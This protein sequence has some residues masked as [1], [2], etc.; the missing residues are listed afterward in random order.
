MLL[1]QWKCFD[2]IS[3]FNGTCFFMPSKKILNVVKAFQDNKASMQYMHLDCARGHIGKYWTNGQRFHPVQAYICDYCETEVNTKETV[4]IYKITK[5]E[6][7][8]DI[9]TIIGH[10]IFCEECFISAA[11][12]DFFKTA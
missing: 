6:I 1:V 11:G 9:A 10:I 8:K 4:T 5:Y 3:I 12:K 2:S 7:Q